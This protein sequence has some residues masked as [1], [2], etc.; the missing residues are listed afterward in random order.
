MKEQIQTIKKMFDET[1][2]INPT[3]ID[4]KLNGDGKAYKTGDGEIIYCE[5]QLKDFTIDELVRYTGIMETL[6]EEYNTH[7]TAYIVAADGVEVKVN[8]MPIK[9]EA[10]FTI[11]LGVTDIDPCESILDHIKQKMASGE[12]LDRE[13]I[14]KL[15]MIP[16]MC[17]KNK[18][19]YY[20]TQVFHIMNMLEL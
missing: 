12:L 6:Y 10:D 9:S 8:E 1:R 3:P 13:D 20:R 4:I 2:E 17:S 11:K 7:C 16:F 18:R 15:Q 14:E 19:D 5:L